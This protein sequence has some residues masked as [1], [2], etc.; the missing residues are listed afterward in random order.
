MEFDTHLYSNMCT[1]FVETLLRR[2]ES[3]SPHGYTSRIKF[4][5]TCNIS[6]FVSKGFDITMTWYVAHRCRVCPLSAAG[7]AWLT[8]LVWIYTKVGLTGFASGVALSF[9]VT[10]PVFATI[11]WLGQRAPERRWLLLSSFLWGAAIAPFFSLISQESLQ[12][13]ADNLVGPTFGHWFR[14]LVITP[15]TEEA[16]KG[17]FLLW[18]LISRR[19][20]FRGLLDGI[21]LGGMIGAGFAF[22]E[23]ILYFGNVMVTYLGS[24]A[25]DSAATTTFVMSLVLRGVLVPF[26]HPFF[27]AF[28]GLGVSYA[29]AVKD[30]SRQLVGV[31]VGFLFPILLHG[32]WDWAGLAA[33]DRFLIFKIYAFVMVPLFFG[34][35][36]FALV[37]RRR[38]PAF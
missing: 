17:L 21:V 30:R 20:D 31:I 32:L 33:N 25:T 16:F 12:A 34:L 29:A 28:I 9:L 23:Q 4:I 22:T 2:V 19:S 37:L 11:M 6:R 24:A 13:L 8:S 38:Q 5:C 10:V 1:Q 3:G 35:V 15:V 36:A 18:L 26:M 7:L 27:V 14:P